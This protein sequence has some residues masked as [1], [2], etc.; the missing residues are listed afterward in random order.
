LADAEHI[1]ARID[2]NDALLPRARLALAQGNARLARALADRFL[3]RRGID[4]VAKA[5]ALTVLADGALASADATAAREAMDALVEL[6]RSASHPRI[7]GLAALVQARVAVAERQ[8]GEALVLLEQALDA[9]AALPTSV[10]AGLAH[11][12]LAHL[13]ADEPSLALTEAKQA[14]RIF[15]AIGAAREADMA[16]ALLRSL[17]DHS[18]VGAKGI[19]GLT[20]RERDVLM[21]LGQG[22]SNAEI[23]RQLYISTKTAGNHVSNIFTKLGLRNRAEAAAYALRHAGNGEGE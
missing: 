8:P 15:D 3:R 22:R 14:L 11:L 9:L 7:R 4:V 10:E 12:E 17:G 19:G 16:S 1:L 6:A 18:R 20:A 5:N 13:R 21:L 2:V 23:A